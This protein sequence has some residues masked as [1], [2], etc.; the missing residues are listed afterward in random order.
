[1][2]TRENA[3]EVDCNTKS[4]GVW[5]AGPYRFYFTPLPPPGRGR[6]R[7]SFASSFSLVKP[8][9]RR[10][11]H[12]CELYC[13]TYRGTSSRDTFVDVV[14]AG[15]HSK[16]LRVVKRSCLLILK[17]GI[18][19]RGSYYWSLRWDA[20]WVAYAAADHTRT[21]TTDPTALLFGRPHCT[22]PRS[23]S[24]LRVLLV[25]LET[26]FRIL[27][28]SYHTSRSLVDEKRKGGG[29]KK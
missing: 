21:L 29:E 26:P 10:H 11:R 5:S 8:S 3:Q 13:L 16:S 19:G 1:M 15:F 2:K 18:S 20:G 6:R 24:I 25:H 28:S 17:K 7:G 23:N 27:A 4:S 9:E 14:A 12:H 22:A